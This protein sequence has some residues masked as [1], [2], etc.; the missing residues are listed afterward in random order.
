MPSKIKH[1]NKSIHAAVFIGSD[2]YDVNTA[3]NFFTAV[4]TCFSRSIIPYVYSPYDPEALVDLICTANYGDRH[5]SPVSPI[6]PI[7]PLFP[8]TPATPG[9][10]TTFDPASPVSQQEQPFDIPTVSE[11]KQL[12]EIIR[13]FY[14]LIPPASIKLELNSYLTTTAQ[15]LT[16]ESKLLLFLCGQGV[17][18]TAGTLVLG[19]TI[20][21]QEIFEGIDSIPLRCTVV[22]VNLATGCDDRKASADIFT[23]LN[24][25]PGS[26]EDLM[27]F[28]IHNGC[29]NYTPER[30]NSGRSY[31]GNG[32]LEMDSPATTSI[33]ARSAQLQLPFGKGLYTSARVEVIR[34]ITPQTADTELFRVRDTGNRCPV[35]DT[36]RDYRPMKLAPWSY[37]MKDW[38]A[39][40]DTWEFLEQMIDLHIVIP[41]MGRV[42][43]LRQKVKEG[44]RKMI[45]MARKKEEPFDLSVWYLEEKKFDMP[46]DGSATLALE[47]MMRRV[48]EQN[49]NDKSL[50]QVVNSTFLFQRRVE[51]SLRYIERTD[52][53][54][55]AFLQGCY[56][57][58][59]F[60][61][62]DGSGIF[63]ETKIVNKLMERF[64][65]DARAFWAII[66]PP[67]S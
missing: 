63:V 44:G 1:N 12:L 62:L 49:R 50:E 29:S 48:V 40:D 36:L 24:H 28:E 16:A 2:Q 11:T 6:S 60:H 67:A 46:D 43:R 47:G 39:V 9:A 38:E 26:I 53:R 57:E 31:R 45:G 17:H 59:I 22:I 4:K 18:P 32:N 33:S 52:V 54:V 41:K 35:G 20:T 7:S 65:N 23:P 14:R 25:F 8:R 37:G 27:E 55:E 10:R 19:R 30:R 13:P 15:S 21:N 5:K 66:I 51:E 61:F 42:K 64:A 34:P 58:G 3:Y 56:K